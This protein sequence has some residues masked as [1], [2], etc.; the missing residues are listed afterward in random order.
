MF[1]LQCARVFVRKVCVCLFLFILKK[2]YDVSITKMTEEGSHDGDVA[3]EPQRDRRIPKGAR[4]PSSQRIMVGASILPYGICA[5]WGNL[6]FLLGKERRVAGWVGSDKWSDFGGSPKHGEDAEETAAREWH[7]ETLGIV[8]FFKNEVLPRKNYAPIAA[9]LRQRRY[10]FCIRFNIGPNLKYVTFVK[11]LPWNPAYVRRFYDVSQQLLH[12]RSDIQR[13]AQRG[14]GPSSDRPVADRPYL[15]GH[16][17]VAHG[18]VHGALDDKEPSLLTVRTEFL[19]KQCVRWWSTP[20]LTKAAS[21]P[22]LVV[23][24]KNGRGEHLRC[25]F[26]RRLR[27]ILR[28]F[29]V[30]TTV[31]AGAAV[32]TFPRGSFASTSDCSLYM[33]GTGGDAPVASEAQA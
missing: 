3:A 14:G 10:T 1:T 25:T 29:P 30:A 28:E 21:D 23:E 27:I 2:R 17:A 20:Q 18:V 8:P 32:C 22:T 5:Q 16:P 13:G 31:P 11:Q 7:E 26:A 9:A 19:E 12:M 4:A 24:W 33:A 6:Y 15:R